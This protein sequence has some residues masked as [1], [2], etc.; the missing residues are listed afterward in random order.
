MKAC[1]GAG[2]A[3]VLGMVLS[4]GALAQEQDAGAAFQTADKALN[5]A[6]KTLSRRLQGDELAKLKTTQRAWLAFRDAEC[7]FQTQ[8]T[9]GGSIQPQLLAGCLAE[10]TTQRVTQLEYYLNCQE[11]DL[12][13]P[14]P[15]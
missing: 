8:W 14:L 3:L 2:I 15:P 12:T 7:A 13:C 5:V 9:E 1:G 6:Y 4:S 10:L 11:G